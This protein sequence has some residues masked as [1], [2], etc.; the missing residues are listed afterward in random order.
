VIALNE[1]HVRRL[2]VLLAVHHHVVLRDKQDPARRF[3]DVKEVFVSYAWTDQS[4][5]VVAELESALEGTGI[6]IR[7]DRAE[8]RYKYRRFNT[9]TR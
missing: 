9:A 2:R 3:E 4:K 8:L 1:A 5:K 6:N 7:Y